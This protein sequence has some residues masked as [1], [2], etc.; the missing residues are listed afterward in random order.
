MEMILLFCGAAVLQKTCAN[1]SE[2]VSVCDKIQAFEVY[3]RV[4]IR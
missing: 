1:V 2:S 4:K 3:Y